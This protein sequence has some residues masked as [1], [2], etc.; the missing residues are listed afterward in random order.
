VLLYVKGGAAVTDNRYDSFFTGNRRYL[1]RDRN[2]LGP[3]RGIPDISS[4]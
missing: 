4:P 2:P 3:Q 1:F